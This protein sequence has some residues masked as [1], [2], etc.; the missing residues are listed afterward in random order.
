MKTTQENEVNIKKAFDLINPYIVKQDSSGKY[1]KALRLALKSAAFDILQSTDLDGKTQLNVSNEIAERFMERCVGIDATYFHYS[2]KEVKT[3]DLH[4]TYTCEDLV[5]VVSEHATEYFNHRKDKLSDPAEVAKY[6]RSVLVNAHKEKFGVLF[7][8][9][10]NNVITFKV[11][12]EGTI[13]YSA[14]YPREIA[15]IALEV[16]ATGIIIA[17]NHP[18]G[19]NDV[20]FADFV[21]TTDIK[22]GLFILGIDVVDHI[23]L[24][25][26]NKYVSLRESGSL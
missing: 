11:L 21:I 18:A 14:V 17:H 15:K 5:N 7:L 19:S 24:A 12:F 8:D 1:T 4:G 22:N 23:I 2:K 3:F 6:L 25:K 26:G 10:Q 13:N 9:N 16:G 20:S